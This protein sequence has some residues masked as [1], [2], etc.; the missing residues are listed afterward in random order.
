MACSVRQHV[1]IVLA[2]A[3]FALLA[4]VGC[5][6]KLPECDAPIADSDCVA[7]SLFAQINR[8][9][10]N[11]GRDIAWET[12]IE[13]K[14]LFGS[15]ANRAPVWPAAPRPKMFEVSDELAMLPSKVQS[16]S[17]WGVFGPTGGNIAG[18]EVRLS[19]ETFDY[20][21]QR[22][23]WNQA[24]LR[25]AY[26][27]PPIDFPLGAIDV[28][29]SWV[30]IQEGQKPAYHWQVVPDE[31]GYPTLVGLRALHMTSRILPNWL[32]ATWKQKSEPD[33]THDSFG[34]N[35]SD[36]MSSGL[37]GMFRRNDVA[38]EM[39][40][41]RLI[42]S[43]TEF[44]KADGT[45]TKLGNSNIEL[46]S[47]YRASCITCHAGARIDSNGCV[48]KIDDS[49]CDTALC[50]GAPKEGAFATTPQLHFVWA[51]EKA[52]GP[53]CPPISELSR[54]SH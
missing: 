7:W 51:F 24:G 25:K 52:N 3:L 36:K 8:P 39:E 38:P 54:N 17:Q 53:S 45:R 41:Y 23:L 44:V 26:G 50:I 49:V 13:G 42:G 34:F 16:P 18:F 2:A 46:G 37:R 27:G 32:W 28:K 21:V 48:L 14:V 10:P 15:P 22:G 30:R 35:A 20:I 33:P 43:Q 19:R 1:K 29:A 6:R 11:S 5:A 40:N 31:S 9:S 47:A 4:G 12:W